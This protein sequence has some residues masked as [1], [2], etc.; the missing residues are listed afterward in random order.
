[1]RGWDGNV[2]APSVQIVGLGMVTAVGACPEVA[3]SA[4]QAEMSRLI[5]VPDDA[6]DDEQLSNVARLSTLAEKEPAARGGAL[7]GLALEQALAPLAGAKPGPARA[8]VVGPP[9]VDA[10]LLAERALAARFPAGTFQVESGGEGGAAALQAVE[11]AARA[12]LAGEIELALIAGFDARTGEEAVAAALESGR[13]IGPSRS[14]GYAPGEAGGALLLATERGARRLGLR[15]RGELTAA[16][17]AHE[18]NPPGK[19]RPCLGTG[20]TEAVRK[21]LATLA[22]GT[23]VD[24]VVCDLNGERGRADEWGFTVPRIVSRLREAGAFLSPTVAWGDCGTA[25]GLLLIALAATIGER[26]GASRHSLVWTSSDGHE[27]AAVILR[28]P[29]S[30]EAPGRRGGPASP[31]APAPAPPWAVDLDREIL[32]QMTEELAFR[33]GQRAFQLKRAAGEEPPEDWS[34][35]ERTEQVADVLAAGLADCGPTAREIVTGAASPDDPGTV[36]AAARV[37]LEA[38]ALDQAVEL[39]RAHAPANP[40]LEAAFLEAFQHARASAPQTHVDALLAAGPILCWSAIPLAATKAASIPTAALEA[41]ARQV[42]AGREPSFARAVGELGNRELSGLLEAWAKANNPT[43]REEVALANVLLDRTRA[44]QPLLTRAESDPALLLPAALVADGRGAPQLLA[45]A[46]AAAGNEAMLA[47]AILGHAEAVPWLLGRLA[48]AGA[49]SVAASALEILLGTA[50]LE[51]QE[52]AD[53]DE[54]ASPRPIRRV[55]LR[56]EHWEPIAAPVMAR[57]PPALRLRGGAPASAAATL[58]LLER[59]RLPL[60]AH[61][62]LALEAVVRWGAPRALGVAVF[63]RARGA[64]A[65]AARAAGARRPAGGWDL[66]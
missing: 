17:F 58:D 42:P 19:G 62:Y 31:G 38:G 35:V 18:P 48:D 41:L 23:Q 14:W 44:S 3:T 50:P 13:T 52:V 65:D 9:L 34:A 5:L 55:S 59:P 37:L 57:H 29:A 28:A 39:G 40:A 27:R 60:I 46:R 22:D 63:A 66:A 36:Y 8:W 12:L 24:R 26:E 21:A 54:T 16:T 30:N 47:L 6:E 64:W 1:M 53:E 4:F 32:T 49:A 25:N 61:R 33:Y 15:V 43:L 20:V 7:F 11:K 10:R 56:R 45:R 2:S 51:E